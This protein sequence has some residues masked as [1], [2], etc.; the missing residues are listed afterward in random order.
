[1]SPLLRKNDIIRLYPNWLIY[2]FLAVFAFFSPLCYAKT[3]FSYSPDI[4]SPCTPDVTMV[5]NVVKSEYRMIGMWSWFW[6]G[7]SA[8]NLL[9][10][11]RMIAPR[12][13]KEHANQHMWSVD[14]KQRKLCGQTQ[15]KSHG[16]TM[17]SEQKITPCFFLRRCCIVTLVMGFVKAPLKIKFELK[18]WYAVN[19][20]KLRLIAGAEFLLRLFGYI[21]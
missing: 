5:K 2:L 11:Q 13:E 8:R 14:W 7:R 12:T 3:A 1:M 6:G 17:W 19:K 4:L 10:W 21:K 15:I 18:I 9:R 16:Q 20:E